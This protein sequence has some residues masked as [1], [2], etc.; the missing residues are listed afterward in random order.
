MDIDSLSDQPTQLCIG[1]QTANDVPLLTFNLA[2]LQNGVFPIP[3]NLEDMKVILH[4]EP[5]YARSEME[6]SDK[7][8]VEIKIFPPG[9]LNIQVM[10]KDDTI[11]ELTIPRIF[12]ASLSSL[13]TFLF[14]FKGNKNMEKQFVLRKMSLQPLNPPKKSGRKLHS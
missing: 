5:K 7:G 2:L 6:M 8:D 11:H 4:Q 9:P 14:F 1:T 3:V 12:F 13:T 10:Y